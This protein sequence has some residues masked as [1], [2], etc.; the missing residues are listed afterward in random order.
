MNNI[1]NE[2]ILSPESV[3]HEGVLD[4]VNLRLG[5]RIRALRKLRLMT[6]SDLARELGIT[7]QQVQKYERGKNR[8][9]VSMMLKIAHFLDA[10][11]DLLLSGLTAGDA[12]SRDSG[13]PAPSALEVAECINVMQL[14]C[15]I[16]DGVWRQRAC[17]FLRLL[18][19]GARHAA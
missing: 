5:E 9:S 10:P 4:V 3:S 8:L 16:P 19:H 13:D 14:Y 1:N 17:E 15:D 7:F 2:V 6:Q 11:P 12:P 18:A